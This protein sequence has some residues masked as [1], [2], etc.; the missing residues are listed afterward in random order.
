MYEA[1]EFIVKSYL[2]LKWDG[3]K[4]TGESLGFLRIFLNNLSAE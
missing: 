2:F 3:E 1:G 4:Y